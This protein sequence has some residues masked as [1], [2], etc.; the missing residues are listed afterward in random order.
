MSNLHNP[1]LLSFGARV[2]LHY[3]ARRQEEAAKA[4]APAPA[5]VPAPVATPVKPAP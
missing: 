4:A 1:T 2:A 3:A 5:Q